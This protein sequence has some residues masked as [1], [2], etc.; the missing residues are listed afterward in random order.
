MRHTAVTRDRLLLLLVVLLAAGSFVLAARHMSHSVW[1]DESQTHLIAS[2]DTFKG[3]ALLAR[4]ERSYPPLFFLA[5]HYSL[6]HRDDEIGL[7]LP[8]AL[9]GALAVVAVFLLGRTLVDSLAGAVAAFLFVLTPGVLRYFADGNGYTQLMLVSALSAIQLIKAARTNRAADWVLY[10]LTALLGLGTHILFIFHL[11]AQILAGAYLRASSREALKPA[12]LRLLAV[13]LPLLLVA[14]G[15]AFVYVRGG[16]DVRTLQLSRLPELS[17]LVAVAGMYAGPLALGTLFQL[18]LWGLLQ[19][20]GAAVLFK[21]HRP[22]FWTAAILAAFPLL[23]ITLFIKATLPYVAYRY[24]LGV[25]PFACVIAASA[26]RSWPKPGRLLSLALAGVY[27]L[28]GFWS[29]WTAPANVFEYQDWRGAAGYLARRVAAGDTVIAVGRIAQLPLSYYYRG[30][31]TT[32]GS[33]DPNG[34]LRLLEQSAT[35]DSRVWVV[36]GALANENPLIASFTESRPRSQN[37]LETGLSSALRTRGFTTC[38]RASFH[39]VELLA[40]GRDPCR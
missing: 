19:V 20:I 3:I 32:A 40:V 34:V 18:A 14:L 11:G 7:R 35:R 9:F 21:F 31:V 27:C 13:T 15:W 8:A 30:A 28:A 10:S 1:F 37:S 17:T 12:Y 29:L 26:V 38:D 4:T 25:F 5:E 2:Q 33:H 22:A 36:R 16:G 6:K 24:A 23:G 39:R